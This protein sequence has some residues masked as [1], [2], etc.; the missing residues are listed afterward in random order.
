MTRTIR[1]AAG[2]YRRLLRLQPGSVR[3]RFT[4]DM[5]DLFVDLAREAQRTGGR[6]GVLRF[7]ARAA[8]DAVSSAVVAHREAPDGLLRRRYSVPSPRLAM[9]SMLFELGNARRTLRRVPTFASIAVLTLGLG[10]AASVTAFGVVN[11]YLIRPLPFPDSERLVWVL[12]MPTREAFDQGIR[13]PDDIQS[14]SMEPL[15]GTFEETAAWD[16]DGFTLVGAGQ[17]AYVDGAWVSAGF[18]RT[19]GVSPA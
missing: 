11:A 4:G 7:M 5:A 13:P 18:F 3:R 17:P 6:P 16:L 8:M 1:F 15:R 14:L 9:S 12:P 2:W 10:I 19:L